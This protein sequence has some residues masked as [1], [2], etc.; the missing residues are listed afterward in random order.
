MDK[1]AIIVGASSG[2]GKA[3]ALVLANNGYK[4]GITGREDKCWN[5]IKAL[6]PNANHPYGSRC[7]PSR[8]RKRARQS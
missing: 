3:L 8:S 7:Y 1:K 6:F 2:I 4:V 5:E